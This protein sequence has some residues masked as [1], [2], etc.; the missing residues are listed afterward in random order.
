MELQ[1]TQTQKLS[2]RQL[3]S[4]ELLKLGSME[5][6]SYVRELA[7]ENPVVE[8]E[9]FPPAPQAEGGDEL[10]SRLN[11]LE[12]NDS[13]NWFYQRFSD[14]ELDPLGRVGTGGGLEET[15]VSFLSRQLGRLKPE[16]DARRLVEY[17]IRC[18]DD[19]G[20]LRI[21]LEELSRQGGIPLARL[22]EALAL[23][24]TL[25]PAGVGAADLSQC[26]ELQLARIGEAGPA[27][28]IVRDHLDLLARRRYRAIA[29]RL[30]IAVDQVEEA[31]RTIR[32]LDPRPGS[33]FQ[34]AEQVHYPQP[35]L[36]VEEREGC[37]TVRS[38]R[39]ERPPFRVSQYYR[40]L[41]SQSEEK[42]VRGYLAEKLRQAENVLWAAQQREGTLLRC[43][44]VIVERQSGFF[45]SG[46][47]GLAPLRMAEVAQALDLHESTVSRAVREKY[48]QCPQ[49]LLPLSYFFSR[50]AGGEDGT[51][52]AAAKNLLLRLIGGEDREKPLSDEGLRKAMAREGC[53]ISRRTVAKYREEL[54]IPAA[55]GRRAGRPEKANYSRIQNC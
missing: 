50:P 48:I 18:L 3:L 25:E 17:L 28:A 24:K 14:E 49:G 27:L 7:Q 46:P 5:L 52:A 47:E 21:P 53:A 45:R 32:E 9:E 1:Q 41:M 37:L 36:V 15:L 42:E 12:D 43:A 11:W 33:V 29:S 34:R 22:E 8:V 4:V 13:Q 30:G 44:R 40:K 51:S 10:L 20:Y 19:D 35:D 31:L 39:G 23:L 54:G 38:A 2:Q 16:E 55:A 6:E 26:L